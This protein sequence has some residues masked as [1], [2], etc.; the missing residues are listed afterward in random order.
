MM[1]KSKYLD[2]E[3]GL[4][5]ALPNIYHTAEGEIYQLRQEKDW[6]I[7]FNN[8]KVTCT[9][10][11]RHARGLLCVCRTFEETRTDGRSVVSFDIHIAS[12]AKIMLGY[13]G[14]Y[15]LPLLGFIVLVKDTLLT[16]CYCDAQPLPPW[17][18][19]KAG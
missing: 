2:I 5:W 11:A 3:T 8:S 19:W 13:R 6:D 14:T 17:Q 7:I 12:R 9:S 1:K 18:H 10:G 16:L 4:N 15:F